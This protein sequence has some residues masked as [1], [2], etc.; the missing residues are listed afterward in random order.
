M[1]PL[2]SPGKMK[3]GENG[4]SGPDHSTCEVDFPVEGM[5]CAACSS[6][7][8]RA[9]KKVPGVS[10]AAVNLATNRATVSFDPAKARSFDLLTAVSKAG[11]TP[12]SENIDLFVDSMT[13][14]GAESRVSRA[15]SSLPGVLSA[16]AHSVTNRV[17]VS[18]LA[19]T[20]SGQELLDALQQSGYP[21]SI[22]Q[23]GR[24][25]SSKE[26]EPLA[27]LW[28]SLLLSWALTAPVLIFSMALPFFPSLRSI[29]FRLLPDPF[30]IR[31]LE[32]VLTSLIFFGPGIRFIKPGLAAYRH[33][34]PDMN[35]LV[36]TGTGAAYAYSTMV[37]FFPGLFPVPD[38]HVYFDSA[39]VVISVILLGRYLEALAKGRTGHSIEALLSLAPTTVTLL[40]DSEERS[41]PVGEVRPGDRI[42]ILP[43]ERI[44][45]D[46]RILEG[47]THV[48][49]SMLTGEPLP[50]SKGPGEFIACGTVNTDSMLTVEAV[51]VGAD[52]RL[53]HIV[54]AVQR[55]Q[56]AKLPVQ[57]MADRIVLVFT[58][59]VLLVSVLTFLAWF[60]WG[61]GGSGGPAIVLALVS[62]VS[63]LVVACPCAM[64]LATP[65]AV[66][67]GSGRAAELG[68]LFRKGEALE[69]LSRIDTLL[70]DKTGTLTL[71]KPRVVRVFP[72]PIDEFLG[73][74]ARLESATSHPM[75]RAIVL[76][77]EEKG[78]RSAS[79]ETATVVSGA[80]IRG[81]VDGQEVLIGS[82]DFLG[83]EGL[84]LTVFEEVSRTWEDQALTLLFMARNRKVVALFGVSDPL[85]PEA[86]EVVK[87][88]QG[89]GLDVRMVTGDQEGV[90]KSVADRMGLRDFFARV[91]PERKSAI[92][93]S[94]RR[95]GRKVAFVGD[96]I[97]DGPALAAA[98]V[99]I[100][101]GSGTDVAIEAADVTLGGSDLRGVLTA[102]ELSEKT[103]KTIRMNLLWAFLYNILLIPLAAGLFRPFF[104]VGLD[105]MLA[106]TAMGLSSVFVLANSLRLRTFSRKE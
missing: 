49:E 48:D 42:R 76:L 90:A 27:A 37:T 62:S 51:S 97:N 83:K 88:L 10:R 52:T 20:V 2:D 103:M 30:G 39:A 4:I 8:E 9:L 31:F 32:F 17:R 40:S 93:E 63:V 7:V 3:T 69:S 94:L 47:L 33:M 105:P 23:G 101:L 92:V 19:G 72:D 86:G 55:A 12:V 71:G 59:A 100:A 26:R 24:G 57:R 96:G 84:D 43:G 44:P 14:A 66:M 91:S 41:V 68:V 15:L 25:E 99:G 67:V 74:A 78:I 56:G 60:V 5:T 36:I 98:D 87:E 65:A 16:E 73:V 53:A 54:R 81:M 80:G 28:Q 29:L 79:P 75:G 77:A 104:G 70:F 82:R 95:Q 61:N 13:D 6:R 50:V 11:Y 34:A 35:S 64:G 106:G 85:K 21:G 22:L 102:L 89:R 1:E 45:V 58:P 46:G 38:R 18:C